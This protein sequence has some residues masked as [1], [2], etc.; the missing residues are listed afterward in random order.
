MRLGIGGPTC[1]DTRAELYP[2]DKQATTATNTPASGPL[3]AMPA[4]CIRNDVRITGQ[5][6]TPPAIEAKNA[7]ASTMHLERDL[8]LP[9]MV[10]RRYKLGSAQMDP[11]SIPPA[12]KATNAPASTKHLERDLP[13]LG[14]VPRRHHP[15]M[16]PMPQ[17][18]LQQYARTPPCPPMPPMVGSG[19]G[20]GTAAQPYWESHNPSYTPAAPPPMPAHAWAQPYPHSQTLEQPPSQYWPPGYTPTSHHR[21]PGPTGIAPVQAPTNWPGTHSA[22]TTSSP[23]RTAGAALAAGKSQW[24][25]KPLLVN[26]ASWSR[27]LDQFQ[28]D[29]AA[30]LST[31]GS[32]ARLEAA[33]TVLGKYMGKGN[34]RHVYMLGD[35]PVGVM[36]SDLLTDRSVHIYGIV[37]H[38][39]SKGVGGALI[40][41]AVNT[42]KDNNG[43][44]IVRLQYLDQASRRAYEKLGFKS[45]GG[46]GVDMILV[47][48]ACPKLWEMTREGKYRLKRA[49]PAMT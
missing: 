49:A 46:P 3:G 34:Q 29:M 12:I 26:N 22:A 2:N 41:E 44:G 23:A 37:T 42:S 13:K 1:Y 32:T 15:N 39:D 4:R 48:A 11:A 7:P 43:A 35:K 21:L 33:K 45:E 25:G 5:A 27:L 38:P 31:R 28:R 47:P 24:N 9:G 16:G 14:M 18:A 30:L 19:G 6:F 10:P 17:Q 36:K 20:Y 8:P 40:E